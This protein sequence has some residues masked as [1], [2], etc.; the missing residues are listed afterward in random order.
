[1]I[2]DG[3]TKEECLEQLPL[4]VRKRTKKKDANNKEIYTNEL[5]S[6]KKKYIA[7]NRAFYA[8]HK[9]WLDGWMKKVIKLENSHQKMEWNCDKAAPTLRDKIIQFRASGIRIKMPTYSPALNLV[10]TQTPIFPWIDVEKDGQI[11]HGRYMTIKEA[12]RLQGMQNVKF[13]NKDFTLTAS[14]SL[15][16]LGNAVNVEIVRKI[17]QKLL[18]YGK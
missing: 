7:S 2:V 9:S 4:Y 18:A 16:A 11:F 17:A 6:W 1:M 3:A 5:P 14:R 12:A 15:E 13:G 8:K 10:G